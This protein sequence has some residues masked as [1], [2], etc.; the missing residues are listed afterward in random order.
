MSFPPFS[1]FL[2]AGN[3]NVGTGAGEMIL[4]DMMEAGC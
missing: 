1:P 2:L 3:G 4:D